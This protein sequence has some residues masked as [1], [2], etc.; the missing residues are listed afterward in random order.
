[1]AQRH[2]GE[3]VLHLDGAEDGHSGSRQGPDH[4]VERLAEIG[5]EPRCQCHLEADQRIDHQPL[6]A[7]PFDGVEDGLHGFIHRQV[8]RP[9]VEHFE[10]SGLLRCFQIQAKAGGAIQ[11]AGRAFL[12][13]GHDRGLALAQSFGDELGGQGGFSGSR[14]ARHQQAVAFENAAPHHFIQLGNA[15]REPS[16]TARKALFSSQSQRA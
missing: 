16:A 2:G 3:G 15:D 1:M 8:E 10:F 12:E 9:E 14:R 4:P 11:I 13:E 6:G 5:A 7:D